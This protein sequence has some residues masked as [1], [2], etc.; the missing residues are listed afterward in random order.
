MLEVWCLE[1]LEDV[2]DVEGVEGIG[3]GLS[4][5]LRVWPERE[6]DASKQ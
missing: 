6:Y 4:L 2:E 5:D 3:V 1:V